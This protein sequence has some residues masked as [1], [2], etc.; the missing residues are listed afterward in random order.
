MVHELIEV[1]NLAERRQ[2]LPIAVHDAI[3]S[4]FFLK[5]R[6]TG[7]AF[8]IRVKSAIWQYGLH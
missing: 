8:H 2:R 5:P 3:V 4:S 7:F 1:V 6:Y